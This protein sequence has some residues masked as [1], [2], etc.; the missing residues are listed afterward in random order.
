MELADLFQL[1]E[2]RREVPPAPPIFGWE[3]VGEDFWREHFQTETGAEA[4]QRLYR[5]ATDRE[6]PEAVITAEAWEKLLK[7]EKLRRAERLWSFDHASNGSHRQEADRQQL[8]TAELAACAGNLWHW[9]SQ[10]AWIETPHAREASSRVAPLVYFPGQ[11]ALIWWLRDGVRV[12][13]MTG[14]TCFR[15]LLK[16]RK[17][18]ASWS[19]CLLLVHSFLFEQSFS[20]K[21]GSITGTEAD[22]KTTYSLLGKLRFVIDH[23]PDFLLP[24]FPSDVRRRD[25]AYQDPQYK[26]LNLTNGSRI[27]GET[28][29]P[30][31]GRSGR[32]V[33]LWQDES[34]SVQASIQA[35]SRAGRTSVAVC[36]WSTSTPRGRGNQFHLDWTS[37]SN[38]DRLVLRWAMD[39]RLDDNW[40]QGL[41]IGHGGQL[42]RD[43]R[44]QEY[45]CSFA[46]VS[47]LRIWEIDRSI[48][49]YDESTAEWAEIENKARTHWTVCGGMDF[50]EGPSATVYLHAILDWDA[51]TDHGEFGRLPRLWFDREVFGYRVQPYEMA[52]M[53]KGVVHEHRGPWG[54]YGDPAGKR[55][56]LHQVSWE[57]DLRAHGVPLSC[58]PENPFA[59]RYYIDK[60]LDLFNEMLSL[61]LIRVHEGRCPVLLEAM[62]GWEWD[63]PSGLRIEQV[64]RESI[65]WKKNGFSHFC[66]AAWYT[67]MAAIRHHQPRI[68]DRSD[69]GN[70]LDRLP[71]SSLRG[72]FGG[73]LYDDLSF[74]GLFT[75]WPSDSYW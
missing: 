63:V 56:Q 23:Q 24:D 9:L 53:I 16:S 40:Y 44:A 51:G 10:H 42:T 72:I 18:T 66:E 29:T 43:Q 7:L 73:D 25:D 5:H 59:Q 19:A 34:A 38:D 49:C 30:N 1:I 37:A 33:V 57:S 27:A 41:L 35:A 60:A 74:E 15:H 65:K 14:T 75:G 61:G 3:K 11:A 13:R 8:R 54:V 21:L 2:E 71:G 22:D 26:L 31:F 62:E 12:G 50:G 45:S 55:L 32:D 58:L 70:P 28:M 17:V 67:V 46:G 39:P 69:D 48:V 6:R 20:A 68:R 36:E 64:N 47:G 4:W 52:Q